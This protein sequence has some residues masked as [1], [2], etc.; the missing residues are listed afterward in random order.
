MLNVWC[1][2][3]DI[4]LYTK[5]QYSD[6]SLYRGSPFADFVN[7]YM[8]FYIADF[9]LHRGIAGCTVIYNYIYVLGSKTNKIIIVLDNRHL[10]LRTTTFIFLVFVATDKTLKLVFEQLRQSLVKI[11][12]DSKVLTNYLTSTFTFSRQII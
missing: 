11:I 3:F 1:F 8:Y 7:M 5:S 6:P 9:P 12:D 2:K 10:G 4:H